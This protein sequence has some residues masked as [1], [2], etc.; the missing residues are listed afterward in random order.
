MAA[1]SITYSNPVY[2]GSFPDPFVLKFAG[3]YWAYCTGFWPDGR[4]FG[5]LRSPDLVEWHEVGGAMLPL[6]EGHTHYWA[7]EVSYY[8]G[9]FYLYYSVGNEE[10]MQIRVA[11]ADTPGGPF[12]DSGRTLTTEQ[13]AID[14]HVFTDDDGSRYLFYATDFLEHTHIGTGTVQNHLLD[15]FTLAGQPR[16]V[17]RARFDWQVYDP[18]RVSKGGV[19]WHTIEGPFLL[20]RKGH[21]YQMFSGGNWQNISYGVSYALTDSLAIGEEW[22][23]VADGEQVLPILR[24]LPGQV[25]GPGHNSVVRGPDNRQ[26]F[27]VYHRWAVD[28][29]GR[30]MAI[31]PLD[32]AGERMLV[33]GPTTEPQPGPNLA[34]VTGFSGPDWQFKGSGWSVQD[35]RAV[36]ETASGGAEAC[37][38]FDEPYFVAEL[39]LRALDVKPKGSF[40][41]G[42]YGED[43]ASCTF[44]LEPGKNCLTEASPQSDRRVKSQLAPDFN[45]EVFHLLRLELNGSVVK[46][47]LDEATSPLAQYSLPFTPKELALLSRDTSAAFAGFSLT[48]GWEDLFTFKE[49]LSEAGWQTEENHADDWHLN[50]QQLMNVPSHA[51]QII[52]K[53]PLLDD[54]EL[55]VNVRLAA[56]LITQGSY[57]FYPACRP[58]DSGPLLKL[59]QTES[60]WQLQ[61]DSQNFPLPSQFD[62]S[63]Y[64]QFRFR[65]HNGQLSLQWEN[66][67]LGVVGVDAAPARIGLVAHQA[68]VVFDMVRVTALA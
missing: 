52:S 36:Q 32:W 1:K 68:V 46:L 43:G 62:P 6:A 18:Q 28:G 39:S 12:V 45:F 2:P 33:L 55:V 14:A 44:L 27:C 61:C 47:W 10:Q 17:T 21:Y 16:P 15:P 20:K 57:G 41:I 40:G 35:D 58:G 42:L 3:E 8:N 5:I 9:R 50:D 13:F 11:V 66:H 65:K 31:D 53:G 4:C 67:R 59:E 60:G 37:F 29:S 23:Q 24:T 63:V 38:S 25:I 22:R 7:P 48:K 26:L 56:R 51:P 54:Y 19:R 49:Q 64:Q 30:E 34:T